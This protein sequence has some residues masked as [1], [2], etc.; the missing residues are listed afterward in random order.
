MISELVGEHDT[1]IIDEK[2]L[3]MTIL[4]IQWVLGSDQISNVI[5]RLINL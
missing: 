3:N 2:S 1:G 5:R 4:Q